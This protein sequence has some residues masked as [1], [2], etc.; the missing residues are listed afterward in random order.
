MGE[1]NG[2]TNGTHPPKLQVIIVGGGITGLTAAIACKEKGFD[3]KVLE[4]LPQYAHVGA[5]LLISSNASSVL[6]DMGLKEPLDKVGTHMKRTLFFTHDKG[7]LL[8]EKTF[9]DAEAQLGAPLWQIH[10]AD[11][12]DVLLNKASE[13]G[14]HL[15]M[16]A[17]V[18]SYNPDEPSL[19]L[20]DGTVLKA[21]II[22]AA[23]GYRSRARSALYGSQKELRF[24][25]YSAFRALIPRSNLDHDPELEALLD[26]KDQTTFV[27][28]GEGNHVLVYP[29]RQGQW[30]NIVLNQPAIHTRGSNFVVQ[31]DPAEIA[32][33]YKGWNPTLTKVIQSLPKENVLEWKLC[34]LEPLESWVF[35]GGKIALLG[36][37]AHAM[38]PSAA[39]GAGM[40]IEDGACI[41]E[42]LARLTDRSQIP[43]ALMAYQDLRRPRCTY[44]VD[45]GRQNAKKWHEDN[46]K[47]GTVTDAIWDYDIKA[48]SRRVPI[49]TS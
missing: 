18:L 29:V 10:R 44:V 41:A 25:G 23:D 46:A 2:T 19:A 20:E 14:V 11:L 21:D 27:W 47:G 43:A 6:C 7:Q 1:T 13:L 33:V 42:I 35:P 49:E 16:G 40:G 48:E 9:H 15:T 12:H 24:S 26:A 45:S 32:E 28:I 3:V 37:A 31:V 5:G 17:K 38:L 22:L 34:D 36:D 39:Q 8:E 4:G 30:L